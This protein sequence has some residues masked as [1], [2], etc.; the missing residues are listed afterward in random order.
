MSRAHVA[1]LLV[2]ASAL[3]LLVG[4]LYLRRQR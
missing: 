3:V 4:G 1:D 2:L